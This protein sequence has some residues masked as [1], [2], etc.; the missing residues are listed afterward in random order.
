M[1]LSNSKVIRR[2]VRWL[3]RLTALAIAAYGLNTA[4]G[5]SFD[6]D[7]ASN[8]V[9]KQICINPEISKLDEKINELYQSVLSKAEDQQKRHLRN[10]QKHWLKHTRNLCRDDY[11]LRLAYW[12]KQAEL[13]N[14][15][16][17]KA[18]LY[19]HEAEKAQAIQRILTTVPFTLYENYDKPFCGKL[20]EDLKQMKG[21]AFVDPL[22]QILSY[23]DPV[24]DGWKQH[25]G[26]K[27]PLHFA[28]ACQPR[29]MDTIHNY[30]DAMDAVDCKVGIGLPPF[31]LYE[32]P[33]LQRHGKKIHIFFSDATYGPMNNQEMRVPDIGGG[34]AQGFRSVD[35]HK[36]EHDTYGASNGVG[37][38]ETGDYSAILIYKGQHFFMSLDNTHYSTSSFWTL[39]MHTILPRMAT[40][41]KGCNWNSPLKP[42]TTYHGEH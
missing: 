22:V 7:K 31:K 18:P 24:L 12:S 32:L 39:D 34:Y 27:P 41:K 20:F 3:L 25:C 23:E 2:I 15:F 42:D 21:I 35:L 28:F 37:Y 19:R 4:Q 38:A 8:K 14:F 17:P 5:A 1:C 29:I 30:R 36:C 16:E 10:S 9:E 11:C 13:A 26:G 6:C 33:P 40:N